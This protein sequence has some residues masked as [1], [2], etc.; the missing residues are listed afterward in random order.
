VL[1]GYFLGEAKFARDDRTGNWLSAFGFGL[2]VIA[3]GLYDFIVFTLDERPLMILSL[4]TMAVLFWVIFFKAT[5][6]L[7]EQ[8]PYK[9]PRL[10]A[11]HRSSNR[12][13]AVDAK[14]ASPSVPPDQTP[15]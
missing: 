7:S 10:A 3:H 9:H 12:E 15:R 4:L 6:K 8:S 11:L 5:R 2:A 1:M 13:A 14:P